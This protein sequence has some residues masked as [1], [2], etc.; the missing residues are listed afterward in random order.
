[1]LLAVH[2]RYVFVIAVEASQTLKTAAL[3]RSRLFL[4]IIVAHKYHKILQRPFLHS[5]SQN[6]TANN[7]MLNKRYKLIIFGNVSHKDSFSTPFILQN[8]IVPVGYAYIA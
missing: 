8:I 1:M 2:V 5:E 7:V 4:Y 6:S 3:C